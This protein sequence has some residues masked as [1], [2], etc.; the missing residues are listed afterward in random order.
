MVISK[1]SVRE[2]LLMEMIVWERMDSMER[3]G[4][5]C[6]C[7]HAASLLVLA[8]SDH[9]GFQRFEMIFNGTNC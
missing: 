5:D 9:R 7:P 3:T 1:E 6:R 2:A 4:F 8:T